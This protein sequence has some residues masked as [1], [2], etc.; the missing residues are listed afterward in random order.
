MANGAVV[1]VKQH[2]AG[3]AIGAV[4]LVLLY[5]MLK[6]G[7]G[8][9]SSGQ[10]AYYNALA[11]QTAAGNA[12]SMQHLVG[13]QAAQQETIA[14]GYALQ[15]AQIKSADNR[16]AIDSNE[17]ITLSAQEHQNREVDNAINL[18]NAQLHSN[19]VIAGIN[20]HSK[21]KIGT[22]FMANAGNIFSGLGNLAGGIGSLFGL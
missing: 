6:G 7:S 4:G 21:N 15:T 18:S 1:F 3:T 20:A 12:I 14:A 9:N 11:A 5:L 22:S 16:Y 19:E 17:R 8:G 13:D 10:A 2:P